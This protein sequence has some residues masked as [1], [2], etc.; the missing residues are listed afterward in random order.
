M[1]Q[2]PLIVDIRDFNVIAGFNMNIDAVQLHR[3]TRMVQESEL[4]NRVPSEFYDAIIDLSEETIDEW[5]DQHD[6]VVDDKVT[7]DDRLFESKTSNTNEKPVVDGVVDDNNWTELDLWS[8]L[9]DYIKPYIVNM[10]AA[11]FVT[12]HGID[13]SSTGM[14]KIE[15]TTNKP[16]EPAER[17][18]MV[19]NYTSR[20]NRYWAALLNYLD[21]VDWT[22]DGTTYNFGSSEVKKKPKMK[23]RVS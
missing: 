21:S 13:V 14:T 4:K 6:Y 2:I 11:D 12:E 10:T 15:G 9:R 17:G 1:K 8:I 19:R 3:F 18:M 20:A 16:I 7:F 5:D 23:I 22:I